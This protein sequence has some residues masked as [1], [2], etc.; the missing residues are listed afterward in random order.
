MPEH[1]NE[2][3]DLDGSST[4]FIGALGAQTRVRGGGY[5]NSAWLARIVGLSKKY[6]FERKFLKRDLS[7]LSGSER[8]GTITWDGPLVDGIYEWRGFCTRSTVTDD[9]FALIEQGRITEITNEQV[10]ELLATPK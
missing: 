2:I 4:T 6:G 8:S 1:Q 10:K 9:G 7:G 5:G 3:L